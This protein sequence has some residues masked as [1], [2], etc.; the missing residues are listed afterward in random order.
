MI[1]ESVF[2]YCLASFGFYNRRGSAQLHTLEAKEMAGENTDSE[3]HPPP[4]TPE[5]P[6]FD[7]LPFNGG[8]PE[9]YSYYE[10]DDPNLT[11]RK[12]RSGYPQEI[13]LTTRQSP[14]KLN[15][16]FFSHDC[17]TS[18]VNVNNGARVLCVKPTDAAFI[19]FPEVGANV[20]DADHRRHSFF[21][22]RITDAK[23]V[24]RY[25]SSSTASS[26]SLQRRR[27]L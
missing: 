2:L 21:A 19:F 15:E 22:V 7:Q 12:Y 23:S 10:D 3:K 13:L 11:G 8:T 14:P 26:S 27:A 4:S 20:F 25:S 18:K 24:G 16:L 5:S 9:N 6:T 17:N 1:L